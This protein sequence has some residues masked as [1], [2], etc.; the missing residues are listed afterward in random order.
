[1]PK[2]FIPNK[3]SHDYSEA[4]KFGELSFVT[5]GM[6]NPYNVGKLVRCWERALRYSDKDDYIVVTSLPVICMI[7]AALFAR[8]HGKLNL[9]LFS[10]DGK[11]RVRQMVIG[12]QNA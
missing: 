11:Y 2:V 8:K 6:M 5:S 12:G 9:L 3:G 7:G 10:A 1:M 4:K